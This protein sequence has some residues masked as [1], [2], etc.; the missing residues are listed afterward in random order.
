MFAWGVLS[1]RLERS[2]LT[3]PIVFVVGGLV[4][5]ATVSV[6]PD[7]EA[8]TVK[9]LSEVTLVW[10]LFSDASRVDLRRLRADAGIYARLL[11]LGLPLT[12]LLGWLTAAVVLPD[13]DVWLALLVGAALAPTDAA[14]GAAVMDNPAVPSRTREIVN[15]ESGLN[16]GIV[17]PVVLLALAGAAA[18]AGGHSGGA[19]HALLQL[20]T[21]AA[22]GLAIGAAG[23]S[24]LLRS[25]RRSWVDEKFADPAV[26][27]LAVL[28]YA[29]AS[30]VG[31]NGFVSAFVAGA[32]FGS[33][34]GRT[35]R[36]E[37]RYVEVTA[38]LA[39]L[40]VWL[41]FGAVVVPLVTDS[42]DWTVVLYALLSLTVLRMAPVAL[43]LVGSGLGWRTAVFIGWFGP[44]GL[45]SVVFAMLAVEELGAPAKSAVTA[46][47][48]T[49]L[50]SVLAH[51]VTAGPLSARY[52]AHMPTSP[53]RV[54]TRA[55]AGRGPGNRRRT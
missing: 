49:V 15:V 24:V 35:E 26:L 20:L 6:A 25:V 8:E 31:G 40:L 16:D 38:G 7:V 47:T 50:L 52:A 4:L 55:P 12:V 51:G 53:P 33:S 34:A 27:A 2:E 1:G 14:L 45:A 42:I 10:V 36:R 44:R 32:A 17:T 30:A 28:A 13:L 19:P 22:V 46:I 5:H 48:V 23:G 54:T 41:L 39:S 21:G 37:V 18:A 43:A 29:G 11:A 3:A 9:L